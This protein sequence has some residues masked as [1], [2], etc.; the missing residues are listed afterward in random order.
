MLVA[1]NIFKSHADTAVLKGIDLTIGKQQIVSIIGK[2][3]AGK[4]TLLHILGTLDK[5]DQGDV[6]FN[7][8]NLTLLSERELSEF[9][10]KNMGFIF[11][12]HHLLPEFNALENVLLP[13]LIGQ[14]DIKAG[15]KRLGRYL[16]TSTSLID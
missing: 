13:Y 6:F 7:N 11:Q 16:A 4:S 10:N 1:S 5:P 2:S 12:F 9:R 3:G 14:N 8:Q 15:E